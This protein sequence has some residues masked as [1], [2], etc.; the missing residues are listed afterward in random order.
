[1]LGFVNSFFVILIDKLVK[2]F[3]VVYFGLD[4][5]M[6]IMSCIDFWI[7]FFWVIR[8]VV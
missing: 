4:K 3:V 1:M 5:E 7:V 2:I 8:D 6:F